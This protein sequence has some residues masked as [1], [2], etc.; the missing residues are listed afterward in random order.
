RGN[1]RFQRTKSGLAGPGR[2]LRPH[3]QWNSQHAMSTQDDMQHSDTTMPQ[4]PA[5]LPT[6]T[7]PG[8][9]AT[10]PTLLSV[11]IPARNEAGC[12]A[13]TIEHVHLELRLHGI[14]HELVV[15]D[16]GSTDETWSILTGIMAH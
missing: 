5:T 15:V 1:R 11:V 14:A 9:D 16:D 8:A 10:S 6:S 13:A 3:L 4:S 2:T 12:I 7:A